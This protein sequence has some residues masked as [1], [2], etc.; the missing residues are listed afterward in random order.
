V[1]TGGRAR[2]RHGQQA[3][4]VVEALQDL[5]GRHRA[6]AYRG[7]FDGEGD[8]VQP[9]AQLGHRLAVAGGEPEGGG[10]AGGTVQ[11]EPHGIGAQ[12][13]VVGTGGSRVS[14]R[15]C[16]CGCGHDRDYT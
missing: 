1:T 9:Q 2:P 15:G 7:E 6:Q 3:E 8:A 14:G 11:E 13:R 5:L 16:G 4:P 12:R 10:R